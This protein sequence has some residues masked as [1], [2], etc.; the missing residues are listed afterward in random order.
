M[1]SDILSAQSI[2]GKG[3]VFAVALGKVSSSSAQR[4]GRQRSSVY[5][6]KA[7]RGESSGAVLAFGKFF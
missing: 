7:K 3:A 2:V 1:E 5:A 6:A 4:E